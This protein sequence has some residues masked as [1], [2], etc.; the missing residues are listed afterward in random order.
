VVVLDPT[1]LYAPL[2]DLVRRL[3]E[4][5][6]LHAT[7]SRTL[8]WTTGVDS[9]LDAIEAGLGRPAVVPELDDEVESAP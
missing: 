6:F 1:G 9:A 8:V 5:G 4:E 3:A 7:A 2:H